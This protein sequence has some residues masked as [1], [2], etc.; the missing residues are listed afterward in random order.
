MGGAANSLA[1]YP[2]L[3]R[4]ALLEE[5]IVSEREKIGLPCI[6]CGRS[7]EGLFEEQNQPLGGTAFATR[8]HYGSGVFDPMDGSAIE[9]NVCDDC[10]RL[11]A[12]AG[13]VA[14][15]PSTVPHRGGQVTLWRGEHL[16][17]GE[18]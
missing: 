13:A 12:D 10:L 1:A 8:G 14:H 9:I 5:P 7:L 6:A 2:R 3:A 11:K 4:P 15:Y 17:E 18:R 16:G